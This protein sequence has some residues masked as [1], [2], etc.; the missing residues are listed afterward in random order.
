MFGN[1]RDIIFAIL[2]NSII[3]FKGEM[4]FKREKHLEKIAR[5]CIEIKKVETRLLVFLILLILCAAMET[6]VLQVPAMKKE[7]SRRAAAQKKPLSPNE[8]EMGPIDPNPDAISMRERKM[9]ERGG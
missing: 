4:Q 7:P 9:R 8:A 3:T 2:E 5:K 1:I 6:E